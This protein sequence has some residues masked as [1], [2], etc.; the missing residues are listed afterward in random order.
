MLDETVLPRQETG[1]YTMRIDQNI[2]YLYSTELAFDIQKTDIFAAIF[3]ILIH[4]Y[5]REDCVQLPVVNIDFNTVRTIIYQIDFTKCKTFREILGSQKK[6]I[7][8]DII[9]N[10]DVINE[11]L[12]SEEYIKDNELKTS[13]TLFTGDKIIVEHPAKKLPNG[14]VHMSIAHSCNQGVFRIEYDSV[15]IPKDAI[16]MMCFHF[17][18]LFKSCMSSPDINVSFIDFMEASEKNTVLFKWNETKSSYP[19]DK[20]LHELFEEQVLDNPSEVAVIQNQVF[21]TRYDL[22]TKAN[23]IARQLIRLGVTTR[24]V[25]AIFLPK[26]FNLVAGIFG[27][28]KSGC[29]YLPIDV[30][31]P[32]ERIRYILKDSNA[33]VVVTEKNLIDKLDDYNIRTL[34]IDESDVSSYP[35]NINPSTDVSPEDLSYVIYTSGSTGE[36]KGVMLNHKGRVNNFTDFNNRFKIGK[37]DRVLAV[38]SP[39]FDMCAYDFLGSLAA[40]ATVV[41]PTINLAN[42]PMHWLQL[43]NTYKITVWH[44]VPVM[45][46]MLCQCAEIRSHLSIQ[47]IRVALLGGDWIPV[48]LPVRFR[49]LNNHCQIVS[50]GGATEASMDSTIYIIDSVKQDW[51]SIPYGRPMANQKTYVL[52]DHLQPMPIGVPGELYIGG[53][54]VGEGYIGKPEI[55]KERFLYDPWSKDSPSRMYKTGDWARYLPNGLIQLLGRLDNQ[56]KLNGVRIELGEIEAHVKVLKTVRDCVVSLV[57]RE[58]NEKM[59]IAYIIPNSSVR[60]TVKEI[61][62]FLRLGLTEAFVPKGVVFLDSFPLTP[63]GKVDRSALKKYWNYETLY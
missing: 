14:G 50:L 7:L 31:Y 20:C 8:S 4:R 63:N 61:K 49:N 51:P 21:W 29:A 18:N 59:L 57:I 39:S 42:Q 32:I 15:R 33:F 6:K 58:D 25:V 34:L 9:D 11:D 28:L 55:S 41:L 17:I 13:L 16:V 62:D 54:G 36:P 3:L 40:G 12:K 47:S 35:V 10:H 37:G 22:N 48:T 5:N 24:S 2:Q 52:D 27:I 60:P 1:V 19:E 44:S 53:V 30:L 43:I 23:D 45:F 46:E 56:V 38:S 26:T